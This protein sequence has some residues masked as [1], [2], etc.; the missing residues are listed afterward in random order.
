MSFQNRA[1]RRSRAL[2]RYEFI[3]AGLQHGPQHIIAAIPEAILVHLRNN[4]NEV[5]DQLLPPRRGD[6][7]GRT[8]DPELLIAFIVAL[9]KQCFQ[10][11]GTEDTI[12]NRRWGMILRDL[13]MI[14]DIVEQERIA[15]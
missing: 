11:R 4:L 3:E 8:W 10:M 7:P 9:Q 12:E 13:K 2:T 5:G 6:A 1:G 14:R 15:A